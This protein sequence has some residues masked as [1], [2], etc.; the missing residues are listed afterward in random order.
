MKVEQKNKSPIS[1]FFLFKNKETEKEIERVISQCEGVLPEKFEAHLKFAHA[2]KK[3]MLV[4]EFR[5]ILRAL[6]TKHN[7]LP[8]TDFKGLVDFAM[9]DMQHKII[10]IGDKYIDDRKELMFKIK[11]KEGEK[12]GRR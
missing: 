4:G 11:N 2:K 7:Y 5:T 9:S 3:A 8:F 10:K 6:W 1:S 12:F